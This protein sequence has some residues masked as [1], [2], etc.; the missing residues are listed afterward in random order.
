[1]YIVHHYHSRTVCL[2][3]LV[4]TWVRTDFFG[5]SVTVS[6]SEASYLIRLSHTESKGQYGAFKTVFF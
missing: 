6:E 3:Q 1:M 4:L 2:G 5:R